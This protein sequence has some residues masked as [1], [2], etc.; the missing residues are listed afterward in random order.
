[1]IE[2]NIKKEFDDILR[3]SYFGGRTEVFGNPYKNEKILHFDFPGMYA[4][5]MCEN[6]PNGKIFLSKKIDNTNEPGFYL[7][8]FKQNMLY[9]ILPIKEDKLYF[10]NGTY[11]G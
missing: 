8:K 2:K 7:I 1:L 11:E 4:S 10:K 6:I 3:K 9:P 5:V